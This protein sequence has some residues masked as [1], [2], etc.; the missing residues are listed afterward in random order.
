MTQKKELEKMEKEWKKMK[1][2]WI[3]LQILS[4]IL[5]LITGTLLCIFPKEVAS[6]LTIV[7]G[8]IVLL[9]GME[10]IAYCLA[11][12]EDEELIGLELTTGLLSIFIGIV[13]LVKHDVTLAFL[14]FSLGFIA[15]VLGC[16]KVNMMIRRIRYHRP[17]FITLIEAL[18]QFVFAFLFIFQPM[19]GF[20]ASAIAFGFYLIIFGFDM[21]LS[22]IYINELLS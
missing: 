10:E 12:W 5:L 11:N 17:W 18:V 4:S 13:F 3:A 22:T 7:I 2:R 15:L 6:S 8:I 19:T 1:R 20:T 16:V 9:Y 14:G 21:L